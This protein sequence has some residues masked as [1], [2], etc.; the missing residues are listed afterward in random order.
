MRRA[1][2]SASAELLVETVTE[3]VSLVTD[4]CTATYIILA[5]CWML[6]IFFMSS[7]TTLPSSVAAS[8]QYNCASK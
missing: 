3:A 1:G 2:L 6:L 8:L 4:Q 7:D 5:N